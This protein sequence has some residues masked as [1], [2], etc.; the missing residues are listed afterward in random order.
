MDFFEHQ[1]RARR[2]TALLIGY[3]FLAVTLIIIAVYGVFALIFIWQAKYPQPKPDVV[4]AWWNPELFI[5]VVAGTVLVI[6]IGSLYKIISLSRGGESIAMSLGARPI[7]PNAKD[8]SERR[9]LNIVEEMSI[10]SGI[11]VPRVFLLEDEESINAFAAGFSPANA[12]IGVTHGCMTL[13]TRDELQGVIAHEFSHILN[14]D[15][16][17]NLRLMGI[18]HGILIIALIGF[19][20]FRLVIFSPSSRSSGGGKKKGGG[21]LLVIVLGLSLIIIGYVGVFF[22]KLIKSAVSRQREFLADAAAVQF[23]RNPGGLGGA[24]KKI[25]GFTGGSRIAHPK[26]EEA[27]HLFFANGLR[28]SFFNLM[29]THPPLTERIQRIDSSFDGTFSQISPTAARATARDIAA[30]A[31][32]T[33]GRT[34]VS[35]LAEQQVTP[36]GRDIQSETVTKSI[37]QPQAEHLIYASTV[38]AAIPQDVQDIARDPVGARALI[39]GLLLSRKADLRGTELTYLQQHSEPPVYQAITASLPALDKLDAEC[40]LP[41]TD[42]TLATLR[43]LSKLQYARFK[44][45][46]HYL[47]TADGTISLFEYT[48]QRMVVRHLESIFNPQQGPIVQYYALKPLLPAARALLSTLAYYGHPETGQAESAFRLGANRLRTPLTLLPRDKCGLQ[49]ADQAINK[50]AVA[51]PQIK[52]MVLA[53]CAVCVGADGQVTRTEAELL[54]AIADALGCPMPPVLPGKN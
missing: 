52:K 18:L 22:A 17:L 41:L 40:R 25:G 5:W 51:S 6:V 30:A 39:Y 33:P 23:T 11:P 3:F 8:M 44:D 35:M 53:A 15:M 47:I 38:M 28:A 12:I 24:L 2:K 29:A 54:R 16:R 21:V 49:P 37:G 10:A 43:S 1:D 19:M 9:L 36:T 32:P 26:A 42:L 48:L 46:L 7:P 34:P 4:V 50:L 13:L 20:I 27:S 31:G 45:N 14:G